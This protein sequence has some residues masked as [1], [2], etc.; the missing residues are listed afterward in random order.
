MSDDITNRPCRSGAGFTVKLAGF[1]PFLLD[2]AVVQ[3]EPPIPCRICKDAAHLVGQVMG[4]LCKRPFRVRHCKSCRFSFV[5]DPWLDF[6]AIY[7]D[8]YYRGRGAD[9]LV[10]YFDELNNPDESVRQYEW[11]GIL[12]V[13]NGLTELLP[14]S[15]WL[16]YGCGNGG[17]VRFVRQHTDN[18]IYGFEE[19]A[20]V[21]QLEN[22]GIPLLA[23]SDL[24]RLAGSFD[25]VTMIE[26]IEHVPDPITT[27]RLVRHLLKPGG[28]LFLTTGN[29]EP[30]R[31]KLLSW[32]YL[33]PEIHISLFEP[34]TLDVALR[35]TGFEP[36]PKPAGIPFNDIIRFKV[37]K[38]LGVQRRSW[39][40]RLIPWNLIGPMVDRMYQVSKQPYGCAV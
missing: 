37:L 31:D 38:N 34:R 35:K 33:I 30:Y 7:S 18:E 10:N 9:P 24:F 32:P 20:M 12:N 36:R 28:T 11:R 4:K 1:A 25:V 39:V 8:D 29:A 19:G 15:K 13:V 6:S 3:Q 22:R 17:L 2:Y 5:E 23:Q 21:H 16:D 26:V 27:L 40:E 14:G